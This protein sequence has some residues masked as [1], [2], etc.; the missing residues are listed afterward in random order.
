MFTSCVMMGKAHGFE[1]IC[2][3]ARPDLLT[4]L[5]M[6]LNACGSGWLKTRHVGMK[7]NSKLRKKDMVIYLIC[8]NNLQFQLNF[9]QRSKN[10]PFQLF[11]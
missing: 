5:P 7:L 11:F 8:V 9:F 4:Q 10:L 2:Q 1:Y 6:V 3:D